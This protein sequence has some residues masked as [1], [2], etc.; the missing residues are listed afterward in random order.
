MIYFFTSFIYIFLIISI[1]QYFKYI[2]KFDCDFNFLNAFILISF[3][4]FLF[5]GNDL[6]IFFF[7]IILT[8]I[9]YKNN[10]NYL[11]NKTIN[12][13]IY[14]SIIIFF[15]YNRYF[16]DE[17]EL[18]FWGIN[19]KYLYFSKFLSEDDIFIN[20]YYFIPYHSLLIPSFKSLLIN[21]FSVQEDVLIMLNN[22]IILVLFF[23]IFILKKNNLIFFIYF[24]I[25]YLLLNLFSFGLNSIYVD[26]IVVLFSCLLCKKIIYSDFKFKY[27]FNSFNIFVIIIFIPLIHR[28]GYLFVFIILLNYL[29]LNLKHILLNKFTF[30]SFSLFSSVLIFFFITRSN[31]FY[32]DQI[33][34]LSLDLKL[35]IS[36]LLLYT[37]QVIYFDTPYIKLFSLINDLFLFFKIGFELPLYNIKIYHVIIIYVIINLIFFKK[38]KYIYLNFLNFIIF[39][40]VIFTTKILLETNLHPYASVRYLMLFFLFD[41]I[42]KLSLKFKSTSDKKYI[43]SLLVVLLVLSPSKSVG[44]FLPQKIYLFNKENNDYFVYLNRLKEIKKKYEPLNKYEFYLVNDDKLT[45]IENSR[46]IYEF[47][48]VIQKFNNSILTTKEFEKL[49]PSNDKKVIVLTNENLIKKKKSFIIEKLK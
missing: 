47:Y 31:L 33:N 49:S 1:T 4:L 39:F 19:S 9:A 17:D 3:L 27:N 10:N 25:F 36:E 40:L 38:S 48:P 26:I 37:K 22:L 21:I 43:I 16:L 11:D 45:S 14:L 35:F 44:F 2:N 30:I 29:L 5:N 24:A 32:I 20:N 15:S 28:I 42:V 23:S 7:L 6:I 46:V 41:F 13:I 8:F 34:S 12:F 18:T